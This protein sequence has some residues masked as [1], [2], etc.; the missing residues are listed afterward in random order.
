MFRSLGWNRPGV[1]K[2]TQRFAQVFAWVITLGNLSFPIAVLSG[3][4]A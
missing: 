4:V 2:P 1:D 3:V